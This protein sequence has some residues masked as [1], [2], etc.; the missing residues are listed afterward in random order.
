MGA[1]YASGYLLYG[2]SS[3]LYAVAMNLES[4]AVGN[5]HK[6]ITDDIFV[7]MASGVANFS[8][9]ENGNLIVFPKP[10]IEYDSVQLIGAEDKREFPSQGE[11]IWPSLSPSGIRAV[12]AQHSANDA[13]FMLS[14][15]SGNSV[16][17]T[18]RSNNQKLS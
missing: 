16:Q 15:P 7:A 18:P 9:S 12:F 1:M 17:I 13:S 10:A 14:L 3:G 4:L 8:V 5:E 11:M 6:L 2:K